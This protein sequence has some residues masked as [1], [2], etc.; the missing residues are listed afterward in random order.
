L[1][2]KILFLSLFVVGLILSSS[3]IHVSAQDS[4]PDLTATNIDSGESLHIEISSNNSVA[5]T[6][7]DVKAMPRT[8][9]SA[10]LFCFGRPVKGGYWGGVQLGFLLEKAGLE[11]QPASLRFYASDGYMVHI[12]NS[13][14]TREDVIIAYELNGESLDEKLRLVLPGDNGQSWIS[15]ITVISIDYITYVS[16]PTQPPY[17]A[18]DPLQNVQWPS[19][20]PEPPQPSPTSEPRS[21]ETTQPTI[22]PPN[23]QTVQQQNYPNSSSQVEY[24]YFVLPGIVIASTL[25][26]GYLLFKRRKQQM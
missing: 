19:P 6:L 18:L 9:V 3:L 15:M 12:S 14:V 10:E 25:A 17:I 8:I 21:Q 26:I 11:E 2:K 16:P 22:Q 1:N 20:T 5:L 13:Y 23:N 4:E 24:G 7:E